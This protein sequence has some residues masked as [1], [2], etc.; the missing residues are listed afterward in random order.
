MVVNDNGQSSGGGGKEGV[1]AFVA[2]AVVL[3]FVIRVYMDYVT[4]TGQAVKPGKRV[5]VPNS[6]TIGDSAYAEEPIDRSSGPRNSFGD[7]VGGRRYSKPA[8]PRVEEQVVPDEH[9][10]ERPLRQAPIE[11]APDDRPRR[12]EP[13]DGPPLNSTMAL[14][15][16]K[17]YPGQIVIEHSTTD[18]STGRSAER[19]SLARTTQSPRPINHESA[20]DSGSLR[21]T[22][23]TTN[24]TKALFRPDSPYPG[25]Y[26]DIQVGDRLSEITAMDLPGAKLSRNLYTYHPNGGPF[27]SIMAMLTVG[28]VDPVVTGVAYVYRNS[29]YNA[30]VTG[31]ALDAFGDGEVNLTDHGEQRVWPHLAGYMVSADREKYAVEQ[32]LAAEDRRVHRRAASS[33]AP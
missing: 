4:A 18:A 11:E 17:R 16:S 30:E 23:S 19:A 20:L 6:A 13:I 21:E 12:A 3:F 24:R 5:I 31:Q 27:K 10:P 26:D 8:P 14:H 25:P 22:V 9:R 29:K 15:K 1:L 28:P 33:T 32:D 7:V 2:I